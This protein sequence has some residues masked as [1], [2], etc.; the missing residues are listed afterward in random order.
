MILVELK[1]K[2]MNEFVKMPGAK[3]R[4]GRYVPPF[5]VGKY[6]CAKVDGLA[7]VTADGE[8][9]NW[10]NY[11]GAIAACEAAGFHL[12]TESQWLSL[13]QNIAKQDANWTGGKV[14]KGNLYQGIR[15]SI[16]SQ[17]QPGTFEP[18]PG[19]RRWFVLSTGERIYDVAGNIYSWVFDD[20]Q[21]DACGLLANRI[22]P[23]SP[24]ATTAPFEA[25]QR[26][27]GFYPAVTRNLPGKAVVRG[28][29]VNVG[30][31][32]GIFH[33]NFA[34]P[35]QGGMAAGFRASR[36]IQGNG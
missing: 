29:A 32:C 8:P 15:G 36:P 12:I 30:D 20:I 2:S 34:D 22:A 7:A 3:L 33:W 10:I 19:E 26:G 17:P 28:G 1:G 11:R 35:E 25:L 16:V 24:T 27:V 14:G 23:T 31:A 4:S 21:G 9:W 6:A 13:A 5:E 18:L